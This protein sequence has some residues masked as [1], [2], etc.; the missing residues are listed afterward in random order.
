MSKVIIGIDKSKSYRVYLTITTDMVEKAREVHETTPLASATLGRVLTA[1]GMMGLMLKND[2]D[3]VTVIFKGEGPAKQILATADSSGNVKGYIANPDV[4]LPLKE[5]GKLDVGEAIGKGELTVIKDIGLKEPYL[6]KI[7][8]VSGEIAEDLTAYFYISEQQNSSVALGVMIGTDTRIAA[9][10][11]FIIQMLPDFDEKA[12]IALEEMLKTIPSVTTMIA[13]ETLKSKGKTEI[14]ILEGLMERVFST[15]PDEYKPETISNRDINWLCDCSKAR[16]KRG[17][18]TLNENDLT[19]MI[20]EDGGA[21][22]VCQFCKKIYNFDV[23]EL[24]KIRSE[25][26]GN[27]NRK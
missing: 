24:K 22:V 15:M 12:V 10:G 21:E 13:E 3:K 6:G 9:S 5:N 7:A 20:E 8:L 2:R 26:A 14:G 1:A 18:M 17:L 25:V 16:Y 19:E 27:D 11:G 23:D 4:D